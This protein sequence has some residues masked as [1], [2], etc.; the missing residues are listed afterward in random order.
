LCRALEGRDL[1]CCARAGGV[2]A[3]KN[4]KM[5]EELN[6]WRVQRGLEI[7]AAVNSSVIKEE[8]IVL[9]RTAGT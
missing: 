6:R 7:F 8:N 2:N 3:L 5:F 1:G 4:E 9:K